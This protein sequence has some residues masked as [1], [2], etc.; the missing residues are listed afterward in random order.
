MSEITG[1]LENSVIVFGLRYKGL[2]VSAAGRVWGLYMQL[3]HSHKKLKGLGSLR[4]LFKAH[5]PR[6][7][8]CRCCTAAIA[9]AGPHNAE[10]PQGRARELIS[11]HLQKQLD[12]GSSEE[13]AR[14]EHI[15]RQWLHGTYQLDAAAGSRQ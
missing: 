8:C 10:V 5:Q 9:V 2:P 13:R 4:R 15:G 3:A 7:C 1:K 14:L 12:E 6:C 11:V